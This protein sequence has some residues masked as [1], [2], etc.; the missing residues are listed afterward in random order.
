MG[1]TVVTVSVMVLVTVSVMALVTGPVAA[2]SDRSVAGLPWT[3]RAVGRGVTRA[4]AGAAAPNRPGTA[5]G[6]TPVPGPVAES[7]SVVVDGLTRTYRAFSPPGQP[8][9]WPLVVVLHG[10]GQSVRSVIDQG[11]L[12][13]LVRQR[14]AVVAYPD[15]VGRSWNAGGGCCG[16]AAARGTPDVAFVEAVVVD[17]LRVLPVERM[18]VYLVG[19][20]NGG[21]LAY[22]LAC[23]RPTLFA[24]VATYGAVPV[25][26]CPA[27]HP[28]VPVLLAVGA[29]DGVLPF[30]GAPRAHPPLP[31]DRSALGWLR[32]E[33]GCADTPTVSAAGR[34]TVQRWSDCAPGGAVES[35][36][37]PRAAHAWPSGTTGPTLTALVW[38]FFTRHPAGPPGPADAPAALGGGA[39]AP[40]APL[41]PAGG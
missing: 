24:A 31:S 6:A 18:R 3:E 28:P 40:A 2:G 13:G 23:S 15:G 34:A 29:R 33:D 41:P 37:Y 30:A 38:D 21:K 27:G 19:Y 25:A 1:V 11:D 5:P 20:S 8:G 36:V 7:H 22:S 16:V 14:R 39:A 32:A 9:R 17:A 12:V 26:A 10:R 35:V 4:G